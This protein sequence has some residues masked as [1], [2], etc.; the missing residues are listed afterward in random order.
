[1][2]YMN[3]TQISN[4]SN[5]KTSNKKNINYGGPMNKKAKVE[6]YNLVAMDLSDEE[7]AAIL[8]AET[9]SVTDNHAKVDLSKNIRETKI[10]IKHNRKIMF[11][12]ESEAH[13]KKMKAPKAEVKEGLMIVDN[14]KVVEALPGTKFKV[15]VGP[16]IVMCYLGGK[17]RQNKIAITVGD[18]VRVEMSTYDMHNG[19]ITWRF[20]L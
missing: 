14:C 1:M 18:E 7:R 5:K 20:S 4:N 13:L 3:E 2:F 15:Q 6:T 11:E 19:R 17:L 16:N 8:T 12:E 9:I 10:E